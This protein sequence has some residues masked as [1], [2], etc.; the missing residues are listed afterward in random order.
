MGKVQIDSKK[1]RICIDVTDKTRGELAETVR[2]IGEAALALKPNFTC[3]TDFRNSGTLLIENRDLLEKGQQLLSEM[4]IGKA[5]RLIN[6]DQRQNTHF[7]VL[8]VVG[9]N[10]RLQ[11]ATSTKEAE[12]ILNR[13]QR[14][15]DRYLK[16]K[17]RGGS[18]F[19][20]LD[21]GGNEFEEMYFDFTS[22]FRQLRQVRRNGHPAAI[23]VNVGCE[24]VNGQLGKI[25]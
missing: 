15:L 4:G 17:H 23:I 7:Q 21:P 24:L 13:Y 12:K 9:R 14:D 3:L 8:D 1:N 5:V 2:Q 11:Y 25:G 19:K 18:M 6:E 10:Y 16:R 22:A 20:I